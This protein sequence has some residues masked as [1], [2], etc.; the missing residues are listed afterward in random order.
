MSCTIPEKIERR[1]EKLPEGLR[2]HITRSR[3]KGRCLARVHDVDEQAVD[4]GLAA[5]DLARALNPTELL[6]EAQRLGLEISSVERHAP[7]LLHGAIAAEWV[8]REGSVSDANVLEAIRW[9]TTG[10]SGMGAVAKAVFLG[11]KLDPQKIARTSYLKRV[12][13]IAEV[14]LDGAILE[15]LSRQFEDFLKQGRIIHPEGVKLRNELIAMSTED[16]D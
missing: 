7:I 15:F 13:V 16:S 14:S 4:L 5:H 11:D 2:E 9:H 1:L 12:A 10:A 3:E 8:T 6:E